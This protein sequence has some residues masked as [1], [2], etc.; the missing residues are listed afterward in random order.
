M[1]K[2]LL[3]LLMFLSSM[4]YAQKKNGTLTAEVYYKETGEAMTYAILQLYSLP[5]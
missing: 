3:L 2:G 1:K 5:D 4:A